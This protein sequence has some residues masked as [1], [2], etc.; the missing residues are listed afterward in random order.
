MP[1]AGLPITTTG[2]L[3]GSDVPRK[4]RDIVRTSSRLFM[5]FGVKRVSVEEICQQANVSKAT[6]YKYFPNKVELF[7]YLLLAMSEAAHRKTEK[8]KR[9]DVPFHQKVRLWINDWLEQTSQASETFIDDMYKA[10]SEMVDFIDGL[11]ERN[12]RRFLDFITD[13]QERGD[14]RPEVNREF[15][16][17]VLRK[18]NELQA[19]EE[20]RR[21]YPDYVSMTREIVDFFFYGLLTC[22]RPEPE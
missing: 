1:E 22:P 19:D 10:D 12:H 2:P 13:A 15:V 16:L 20:L 8:I 5:R 21:N 6:F 17:A 7:K 3:S 4:K 11:V 9:M 14:V 18:M